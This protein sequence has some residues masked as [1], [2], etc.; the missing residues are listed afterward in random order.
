MRLDEARISGDLFEVSHHGVESLDV[1]DLQDDSFL[2]GQLHEFGGLG[3]V[4]GHWFFDEGVFAGGE[5]FPGEFEVG[6][7]WG[8]DAEGIGFRNGFFDG[9]E[10]WNAVFFGDAGGLRRGGV[11]KAGEFDL[12]GGG[13]FGIDAGVF[14]AK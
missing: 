7:G 12:A 13:H 10:N 2:L 14:F 5:N 8:D 9:G 4:V 3:C 1:A 11:V 6:A